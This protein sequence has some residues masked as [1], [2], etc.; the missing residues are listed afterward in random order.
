MKKNLLAAAALL[1]VL[2]CTRE[3]APEEPVLSGEVVEDE[4]GGL[5]GMTIVQFD[6]DMLSLIEQDLVSGKVVT[7][8][9][10]LNDMVDALGI[11]SMEA[12]FPEDECPEEYRARE[13]AFGLRRWYYVNFD[14]S[15]PVTKAIADLSAVKGIISV[16]PVRAVKTDVF[17]D[18][19]LSQQWGFI[20]RS[21]QH[22]DINVQEVWD[23]YTTGNP[24]V[25]VSVVDEGVDIAHED[26]ADNCLEGGVGGNRNFATGS[27][28]VDPMSHGTHVA[29][30]I[31]AINNNGKGVCGIAGGDAQKKQ[32]GVKIMSCQFFGNRRNGSSADAIR[33]GA[34]NGALIS[35]NSWGYVADTNN[36]GVISSSERERALKFTID[37]TTKAA[38]DYFIRYAGC[39]GA[40]NQKPDSPMKGGLVVFAAGNDNLPNGAPANYEKVIAV[41]AMDE[42]GFKSNFSNYG[43]WV[44]ICAPGTGILS[45]LPDNKY[46]AMNGTSMACP[47][48]SGVAALVVSYCGKQ[49]FTNDMLW[50]KLIAS[51]NPDVVPAGSQ[52]GPLVDAL[53]AILFGS[54][55]TPGDVEEYVAEGRSN[56]IDFTWNVT[57]GSDG[58]SSYAAML[59]ASK[60]KASLDNLDPAKPAADVV[61]SSA[62]TS[63]VP[64]GTSFTGTISDLEFNTDYYVTMIPYSYSGVYA[65][66]PAVKAVSTKG[67][68]PPT[69]A[70]DY[71]GELTFKNYEVVQIPLAIDEPDGHD[72]TV[73]YT[74][75]GA[76]DNVQLSVD[77]NNRSVYYLVI[78]G[79]LSADGT[80]TGTVSVKDQY[81]AE[82]TLDVTYTLLLNH[83]PKVI[84]QIENKILDAELPKTSFDITKVFEDEDGEP[85]SLDVKVSDPTMLITNRV[86]DILYVTA[87]RNGLGTVTVTAVDARKAT[88]SMTFSIL[89][90]DASQETMAYPNPVEDYLYVSTGSEA[91]ETLLE[92]FSVTGARIYSDTQTTS[93]FQPATIDLGG[94]APGRYT[95]R[96]V[97]GG[98]EYKQTIIK[99]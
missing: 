95:L 26:L 15:R 46:G 39:D 18:V 87:V 73:T 50:T 22:A 63:T 5:E 41:G 7:K 71:T 34:N 65:K 16:E 35:Q 3:L 70:L 56:N 62:L 45:T 53:G 93:A 58:R 2:A 6:D 57:E 19:G 29:G 85:L 84:G 99:K 77:E 4:T 94:A 83:A 60:N 86:D 96:Y 48:V 54:D 28:D 68:N 14:E 8:S 78:N 82:A 31:A 47:H 97:Y 30:T 91:E 88:A 21:K 27:F 10:D 44:D 49:G 38:V 17:N 81:G 33:W 74:P 92:V 51:A 90:R 25:I 79:P 12:V 80:F 9:M 64:V 98:K 32:A 43:D 40:G 1:A 37:G 66:K 13:R 67:N 20:N 75:G 24:A 11:T 42:R 61:F 76:A 55:S 69:V 23:N 52:V 89:V 36:D 72:V 59:F